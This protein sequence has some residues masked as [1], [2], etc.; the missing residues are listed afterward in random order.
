MLSSAA[1]ILKS[2]HSVHSTLY[3]LNNKDD[4]DDEF[5]LEKRDEYF[6]WVSDVEKD[7]GTRIRMEEHR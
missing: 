1:H 5:F 2:L 7:G 4:D 3:T 6:C